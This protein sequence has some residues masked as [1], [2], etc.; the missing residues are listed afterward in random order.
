MVALSTP[1]TLVLEADKVGPPVAEFLS[2]KPEFPF[3]V[4]FPSFPTSTFP[5]PLIPKALA[6]E[7]E[8]FS[9]L[10]AATLLVLLVPIEVAVD[11]FPTEE[12]EV[13]ILDPGLGKLV[14]V[15]VELL[16]V[17]RAFGGGID[18]DEAF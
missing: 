13:V 16:L 4:L 14:E 10:A 6:V 11:E 3:P 5:F 12:V 18:F 8:L 15:E 2:T 17:P 1:T 7:L 9:F